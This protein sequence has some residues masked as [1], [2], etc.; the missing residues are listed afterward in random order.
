MD[1]SQYRL[2]TTCIT[3]HVTKM[4][5]CSGAC[6]FACALMLIISFRSPITQ[7]ICPL[8]RMNCP[9]QYLGCERK[10]CANMLV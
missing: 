2:L 5:Q 6:S 1:L 10:V 4:S 8:E 9:Y 7:T 3:L